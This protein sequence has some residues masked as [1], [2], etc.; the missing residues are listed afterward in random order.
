MEGTRWQ[1][2]PAGAAQLHLEEAP[3][4][5]SPEAKIRSLG[6]KLPEGNAP[7]DG[8]NSQSRFSKYRKMKMAAAL[9][10]QKSNSER[11]VGR[12]GYCPSKGLLCTAMAAV[13][14][15]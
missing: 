2:C 7:R 5:Q 4:V 3:T 11:G 13:L 10:P 15:R 6:Y 1:S 9:R 8:A 12:R 14:P